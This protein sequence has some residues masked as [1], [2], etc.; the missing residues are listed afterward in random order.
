MKPNQISIESGNES[1]KVNE[2]DVSKN[3][4]SKLSTLQFESKNM[5][6]SNLEKKEKNII[7]ENSFNEIKDTH[8]GIIIQNPLPNP[9]QNPNIKEHTNVYYKLARILLIPLI[10]ENRSQKNVTKYQTHDQKPSLNLQKGCEYNLKN[11][12]EEK[13]MKNF[14]EKKIFVIFL[15]KNNKSYYEQT[16]SNLLSLILNYNNEVSAT[17][18]FSL[19]RKNKEESLSNCKESLEPEIIKEIVNLLLTTKENIPKKNEI[20]R[21]EKDKDIFKYI[22]DQI[23]KKLPQFIKDNYPLYKLLI[24]NQEN[25]ELQKKFNEFENIIK[26]K[27][28]QKKLFF[29]YCCCDYLYDKINENI[30]SKANDSFMKSKKEI[31]NL[32][33]QENFSKK[34]IE[35]KV[36]EFT[37]GNLCYE[38][39]KKVEEKLSSFSPSEFKYMKFI[40]LPLEI[41]NNE[42]DKNLNEFY[43]ESFKK[44]REKKKIWKF[45]ENKENF[46]NFIKEH[47]CKSKSLTVEIKQEFLKID[48]MQTDTN[49][50]L[51]KVSSSIENKTLNL[52]EKMN[53][54][55]RAHQWY[56][57]ISAFKEIEEELKVEN[58]L[59]YKCFLYKYFSIQQELIESPKENQVDFL[60][61][62]SYEF[63]NL[64]IVLEKSQNELNI[65][66]KF[67]KD[68]C[69]ILEKIYDGDLNCALFCKKLYFTEEYQ[70][71]NAHPIILG[72]ISFYESL[73]NIKKKDNENQKYYDD[74]N[75][76]KI[77]FINFD[78]Y[79]HALNYLLAKRFAKRLQI[80]SITIDGDELCISNIENVV[81]E[82]EKNRQKKHFHFLPLRSKIISQDIDHNISSKDLWQLFNKIVFKLISAFH[83]SSI[84]MS[85]SFI[86]YKTIKTAKNALNLNPK[87]FSKI[88]Q[89]L[90]ILSNYKTVL[91]PNITMQTDATSLFDSHHQQWK[92]KFSYENEEKL[93]DNRMYIYE[94]LGSYIFTMNGKYFLIF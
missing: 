43:K 66:S 85:H 32:W 79:D 78:G 63:E 57:I 56:A 82:S 24:K 26:D 45:I 41:R 22:Y 29:Y 27:D 3:A 7:E 84:I 74:N 2:R 88:I 20:Y 48:T 92:Q 89:R 50:Q 90:N 70:F 8:D 10:K 11:I 15:E 39:K 47:N 13:K 80:I 87:T 31:L 21:P 94:M 64:R 36:D 1:S 62:L 19:I 58:D 30:D 46:F 16:I 17:S 69:D 67:M 72:I 40:S 42:E 52:Y 49:T 68:F 61:K 14:V 73:K 12:Y 35:A 53:K 9:K 93:Y 91:Y 33:E 38:I 81:K 18:L 6:Y 4:D 86:F 25:E 59:S 76:P 34:T 71:F 51:T 83:P 77:T 60:I 55:R 5:K 65:Y 44:F 37:S 54:I 28:D 23:N 75:L